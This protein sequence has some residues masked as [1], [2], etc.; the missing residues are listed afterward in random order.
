MADFSDSKKTEIVADIRRLLVTSGI[1]LSV[2]WLFLSLNFPAPFLMGS[3]FGVWICGAVVPSARRHLGVARWFHVPVILGLGVLMGE[4]FRADILVNIT[5]WWPTVSTMVIT[6]IV[7]SLIGY[8]F[9][10]RVR[11]YE[12]RLALLCCLPGGQAEAVALAREVV[13]KAYVVALFHLVRV[14]IVFVT[15]PLLMAFIE[16]KAATEASNLTLRSMPGLLDLPVAE[17]IS[18]IAV[19][20]GG[21]GLAR[22]CRVPMAHLLGPMGLSALLH[23]M[24]VIDLPRIQEFVL[25]A[26][27]AIGGGVGAQLAR[28]PLREVF[29]YLRDASLN[30]MVILLAYLACAVAFT[31]FGGMDFLTIWLAFVPGGLYEV[32]LLALVF[33]F[34]VAFTAF[35]H[36]IRVMLIFFTMP[37]LA[38][39]LGR[40]SKDSDR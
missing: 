4:N 9:L 17:I 36:T 1:A 18:F 21:Y 24:G 40:H 30:T 34:D 27:L 33:G 25:L 13:D 29:V 19:G 14:V 35:H 32:T 28:V 37:T 20:V 38:T 8:V 26:Q 22:L 6:T 5:Q 16:G 23:V 31:V 11:G 15:M 2:G 12:P 3:L 7:V 39:R 10:S